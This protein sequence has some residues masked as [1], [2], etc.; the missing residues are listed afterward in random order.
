M[1]K[2]KHN[3]IIALGASTGGLEE[4]NSFFDYTPLD[5]V[6]YVIVQHL[7]PELKRRMVEL[8]ARHSKLVIKEA[9]NGM[10]VKSNQVYMIPNDQFMTIRNRRLYLIDQGEAKGPH[11]TIDRFFNS[12][13]LNSGRKSIGIILA[14]L[15]TDGAE[16]VTAIK[17][18]GGFIMARNPATTAYGAM[19]LNAIATGMVDFILEPESMPLSIEAY[20]K[21]ENDLSL[22]QKKDKRSMTSIFRV[23]KE[24]A[25]LLRIPTNARKF[26][27]P[28][29]KQT[30]E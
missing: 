10:A 4:I 13:A 20:V 8:L 24:K 7:S 2:A 9:K 1:F 16:G 15:G 21:R 6:S 11:F 18:T 12:L 29:L 26:A 3:Y 17:K 27:Q 30:H 28:K 25:L 14:G 23:I 22:L 5:G 19:S